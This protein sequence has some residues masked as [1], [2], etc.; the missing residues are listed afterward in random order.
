MGMVELQEY[1]RAA[2]A[3]GRLPPGSLKIIPP[4]P[5]RGGGK[6]G[7]IVT[8]EDICSRM[9]GQPNC[10]PPEVVK[11]YGGPIEV[12][13]KASGPDARKKPGWSHCDELLKKPTMTGLK[14]FPGK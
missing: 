6:L 8:W 5:P 1:V 11:Y 3:S 14:R 13:C 9:V 12:N 2:A 10:V 4:E 7:P